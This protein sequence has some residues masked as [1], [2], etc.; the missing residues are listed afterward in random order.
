[1]AIFKID[2]DDFKN[3]KPDQFKNESTILI[4]IGEFMAQ[5]TFPM[6]VK[7]VLT[8]GQ[9]SSLL[10][11]EVGSASVRYSD[12]TYLVHNWSD[13][14]EFF[15]YYKWSATGNDYPWTLDQNA[16]YRDCD[17]FAFHIAAL[18]CWI[19]KTNTFMKASGIIT[20]PE[21]QSGNH[22]YNLIVAKDDKGVNKVYLYDG[23][24]NYYQQFVDKKVN[25]GNVTY[26]GTYDI[27][28]I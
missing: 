18:A 22:A 28:T 3:W 17:K 5:K 20:W 26:N 14:L 4:Q 12:D 8:L 19:F 7:E 10:T 27:I 15:K 23:M 21:K 16:S 13:W 2:T 9:L 25:R 24:Y 1:M 6:P 11:S